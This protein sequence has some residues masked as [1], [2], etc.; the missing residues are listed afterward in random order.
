MINCMSLKS[1]KFIKK[2]LEIRL[3]LLIILLKLI[4]ISLMK[5]KFSFKNNW[6][7]IIK[8]NNLLLTGKNQY[9][10]SSLSLHLFINIIIINL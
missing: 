2:S 9:F 8:L 5:T 10:D 1:L 4:I 6:I 3:I 7:K